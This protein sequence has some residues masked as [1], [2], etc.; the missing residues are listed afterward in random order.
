M[1]IMVSFFY[2]ISE[3]MMTREGWEVEEG[4]SKLTSLC[5]LLNIVEKE[6]RHRKIGNSR[7]TH[8][9]LYFPLQGYSNIIE[10]LNCLFLLYFPFICFTLSD[11][12]SMYWEVRRCEASRSL[13]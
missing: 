10:L 2:W 6:T 7:C 11:T 4:N 3:K 9:K 12:I 5:Y 1:G 8:V 13:C